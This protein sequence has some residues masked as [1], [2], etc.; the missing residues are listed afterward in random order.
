MSMTPKDSVLAT[1]I[2]AELKTQAV[3]QAGEVFPPDSHGMGIPIVLPEKV[4][5]LLLDSLRHLFT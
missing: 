1:D 5:C 3:I 2:L 4:I